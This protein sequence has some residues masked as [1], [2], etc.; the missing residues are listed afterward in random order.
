MEDPNNTNR[1]LAGPTISLSLELAGF[2]RLLKVEFIDLDRHGPAWAR[3]DALEWVGDYS[4]IFSLFLFLFAWT[5]KSRGWSIVSII[6]A[7]PYEIREDILQHFK[8][9]L[10]LFFLFLLLN[11]FLY[12]IL[13]IFFFFYLNFIIESWL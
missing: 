7:L 3:V 13:T 2:S 8:V 1:G 6:Y 11:T 10:F 12:L 9:F 5:S 4:L